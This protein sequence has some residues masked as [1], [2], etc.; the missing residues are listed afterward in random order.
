MGEHLSDRR[1]VER[2]L[3]ADLFRSVV[4]D[5]ARDLAEPETAETLRRLN[6]VCI[7]LFDIEDAARRHAII[8]R[9][10]RALAA[11]APFRRPGR[12]V[13]EFGLTAYHFARILT[14]H[15][16]L[17]IGEASDL[18]AALDRLLPALAEAKVAPGAEAAAEADAWQAQRRL[19][20][21]GYFPEAP[22]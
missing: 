18:S 13:A 14:D 8:R 21:E 10:Q 1:R 2:L 12:P 22:R 6:Q 16:V 5:G 4:R 17:I 20:H 11:F 9:L 7:D 3:V 15:D 19:Q